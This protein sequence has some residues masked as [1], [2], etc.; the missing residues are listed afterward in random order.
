VGFLRGSDKAV[1]SRFFKLKL[2]S[3]AK[4]IPNHRKSSPI[5]LKKELDQQRLRKLTFVF[6]SI[7]FGLVF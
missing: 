2:K 3:V 7:C 4:V 1:L 5:V 6:C